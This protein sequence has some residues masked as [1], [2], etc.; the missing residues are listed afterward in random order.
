MDE[1]S[2][3]RFE[4][5]A[6]F[7][8][9]R[10]YYED[11]DFSGA[12]Y[13][14]NYL[15][16]FERGRSDFLRLAGVGHAALLALPEPCAFAVVRLNV[17]FLQAARIDDSLVVRTVFRAIAGPRLFIEQELSRAEAPPKTARL[18]RASVEICCIRRGSGREGQPMR[19]PAPL[20][21]ALAPYLA[22]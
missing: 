5:G 14:A 18:C 10:V 20:L 9:V 17:E 16:F 12:V 19:P 6:H 21:A 3:G 11:T 8:P 4:D 2:S 1:P 15:K 22:A 13:H 7:L